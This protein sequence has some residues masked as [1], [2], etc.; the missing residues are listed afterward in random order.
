MTENFRDKNMNTHSDTY[1]NHMLE[2]IKELEDSSASRG[3]T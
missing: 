3:R 2:G 1:T